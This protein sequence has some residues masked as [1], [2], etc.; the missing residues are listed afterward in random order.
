MKYVVLYNLDPARHSFFDSKEE[1][2]DC[3]YRSAVIFLDPK[4]LTPE[5]WKDMTPEQ[6]K[7]I[8]DKGPIR[9]LKSDA[10]RDGKFG[11]TYIEGTNFLSIYEMDHD[12]DTNLEKFIP[13][14]KRY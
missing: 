8:I 13:K 10:N 3:F 6:R 11:I 12:N 1:A 2:L 5:S 4:V 9:A 14:F 7:E